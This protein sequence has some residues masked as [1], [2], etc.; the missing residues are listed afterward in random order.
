MLGVQVVKVIEFI[1]VGDSDQTQTKHVF[2][3]HKP[4]TTEII[5]KESYETAVN[6]CVRKSVK[7]KQVKQPSGGG[8]GNEQTL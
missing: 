2:E 7:A 4:I 6:S 8:T 5:A 3:T 1:L